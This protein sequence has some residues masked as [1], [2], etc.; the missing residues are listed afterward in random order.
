MTLSYDKSLAPEVRRFLIKVVKSCRES[1]F[2]FLDVITLEDVSL[3]GNY[4]FYDGHLHFNQITMKSGLYLNQSGSIETYNLSP[5]VK[6]TFRKIRLRSSTKSPIPLNLKTW[7]GVLSSLNHKVSFVWCERGE[8]SGYRS[9]FRIIGPPCS[10]CFTCADDSTSDQEAGENFLDSLTEESSIFTPSQT[11]ESSIFAP[12]QVM[13]LD[14]VEIT[15]LI[16]EAIM[17]ENRIN[18]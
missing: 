14:D 2:S 7:L 12:D 16:S 10:S 1:Y 9:S 8:S 15:E 4:F 5:E 13:F 6:I 11:E 18:S 3:K 17:I